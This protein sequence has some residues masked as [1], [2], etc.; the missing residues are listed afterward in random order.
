MNQQKSILI[1]G[2]SGL[3]G[4][5]LTQLLLDSG[6]RVSHLS[7]SADRDPRVKI[8]RWDVKNGA[9]DERCLEGVD[10]IV[11]L[12]GAGIADKRWTASRKKEI[13]ESRT[14]SIRLIYSLMR[15]RP[16][17]VKEVISASGISIY[18]DR[19]D[20]WLTE[21]SNPVHDFLGEC[22]LSW[23][24]AVDEG[25]TFG[26]RIVKFRTGVVLSERGGALIKM[27]QPVRLYAGAPLGSG[28]QWVPWIH[29]NDVAA[30]YRYAIIDNPQFAGVFNMVAPAPVTNWQLT[31]AI[32]EQLHKP[33]WLPNVPAFVMKLLLGEMSTVVLS[34]IRASAQKILDT[35]FQFKYPEAAAALKEIYE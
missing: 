27:A 13:V 1:T 22:C 6:C 8:F 24:A 30:L 2:G 25:N 35:G 26:L 32:A 9:I 7:R 10:T 21:G 29:L 5:S 28:K 31:A 17:Q 4:S 18:G 19:G 11:H 12:A 16:N 14:E 34:S 15:S 23:E 20:D 33:L 3:I